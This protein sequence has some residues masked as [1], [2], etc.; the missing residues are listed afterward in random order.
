MKEAA[1]GYFLGMD[2]F[3]CMPSGRTKAGDTEPVPDM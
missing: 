3:H 1:I 2:F